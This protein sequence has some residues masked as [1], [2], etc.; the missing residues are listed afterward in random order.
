MTCTIKNI[1]AASGG[2][3]ADLTHCD[4][5]SAGLLSVP[6]PSGQFAKVTPGSRSLHDNAI[7]WV[8]KNGGPTM[9][10]PLQPEPSVISGQPAARTTLTL[11]PSSLNLHAATPHS[12]V[13]DPANL[14]EVQIDSNRIARAMQ[15]PTLSSSQVEAIKP[16]AT[17]AAKTATKFLVVGPPGA[18]GEVV[19]ALRKSHT[20]IDI[21]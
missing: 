8:R 11:R 18:L 13:Q 17:F 5:K 12:G 6:N 3:G 9:A 4:P 2:R 15:I 10:G 1:H 21:R 16:Y 7:D 19:A 20:G 14:F